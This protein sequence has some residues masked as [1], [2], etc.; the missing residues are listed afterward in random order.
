MHALMANEFSS[1]IGQCTTGKS[2]SFFYYSDDGKYMLKT[3]SLEEYQFFKTFLQN[4]Y[5]H[6]YKN[7]HTLITRFFGFHK[8]IVCST[9][10]KL[11]FVVMGN[12]FKA[13]YDLDIKYD[14][15]GSSLGRFTNSDEDKTIARK[16]NNFNQDKRKI[17]IGNQK[18]GYLMEQITKDCNLMMNSEI[19]DY[20]LLLGICSVN[21]KK[22]PKNNSHFTTFAEVDDGGMLN[23]D[24]SELYF[25]GVI[26][27][28]THYGTR[29]KL[30]HFFKTTVN[31]K[32]AVSCVPPEF[33]AQRFIKYIDSIIE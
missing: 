24:H 3:L 1:L 21:R 11:Y 26:D 8:I 19:I 23:E 18:K 30:E 14:L 17:R 27:I 20:S 29:K 22:I 5:N 4:Y 28:L 33:Y 13:D 25:L 31:K 16:D 9:N 32:E 12:L 2:G 6:L 10:K 7:P 15:K